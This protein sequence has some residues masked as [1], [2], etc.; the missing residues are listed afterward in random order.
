MFRVGLGQDSHKIKCKVQSAK[1][2]ISRLGG[3]ELKNWEIIANSDGDVIIHALCNALNTA[4]GYGSLDL[5]AGPMFKKG[6][7]DS[8]EYLKVALKM[9][10]E[11]GY[12]VNNLALMIEAQKPRLEKHREKI[13]QSLAKI[14]EMN[15]SQIGMAFTSGEGLTAFGKGKG[16]QV[17][18]LVSLLK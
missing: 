14:L 4:I 13:C 8:R 11:R 3:I 7:T 17:F 6:I 12:K 2:K 16:I 15:Q 10:K 9:A 18:C 5:Y 1:C